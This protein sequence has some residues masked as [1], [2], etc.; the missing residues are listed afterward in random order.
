MVNELNGKDFDLR[1]VFE[2]RNVYMLAFGDVQED[3]IDEEK[4]RFNV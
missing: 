4:E 2:G 3:A 1:N